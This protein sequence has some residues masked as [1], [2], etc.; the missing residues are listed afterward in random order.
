MEEEGKMHSNEGKLL[1]LRT[2]DGL[3][4]NFTFT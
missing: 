3:P 2:P 4:K 1:T